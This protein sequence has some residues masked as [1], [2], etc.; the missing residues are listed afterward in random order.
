M[1]ITIRLLQDHELGAETYSAGEFIEVDQRVAVKLV[2][3]L[4]AEEKTPE[5]AAEDERKRLEDER[6]SVALKE[7][8]VNMSHVKV[9][10]ERVL[11]DPCGGYGKCGFGTFLKD[12]ATASR[13]NRREPERLRRWSGATAHSKTLH[14]GENTVEF[15]D[16]QGG[17]LIPPEFS[18]R[19]HNIQLD[20]AT[21]RP[22]ATFF[23]MGTNR[24]GINA[25]VD[26]D[27]STNLF[28][29]ISLTRPGEAEQKTSS[30]AT[31]RQV[32]LTLHKLTGLTG[33]SDEMIEDSPQSIETLI[34]TLFGQALAFQEDADFLTG[35]GVGQPLGVIG[36]PATIAVP[37]EAAQ[38]ANTV[39]AENVINMWARMHPMSH[40][41]AVWVVN[42]AVQPQLWQMGL[43][44]GTGG[45][46]VFTPAGGLSGSPFASLM[47]R[48]VIPSEHPPTLGT[49]GDIGL[50]DFTQYAIGGKSAGGA[51]QIASSTHIYFDYDL[52]AFRFVLRYDGQPL[53]RVPL[54]PANGP[55]LS[56]FVNLAT[57]P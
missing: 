20:A 31:F 56:P 40:R 35:T 39:I 29:G 46:L 13:P 23:P 18:A 54:T 47:G 28:G 12:V 1:R 44:V 21:V 50:Y 9:I 37:A 52:V 14:T 32:W 5:Q 30:K 41:N 24:I 57:R 22:R 45:S 11:N 48:P 55:T 49:I 42:H 16:S 15:D 43:A 53:W 6:R 2:N 27:H 34:T 4:I 3:D 36:A 38:P 8:D 33:V 25:V 26:E 7:R 51:P 17:Y 10:G 19:L